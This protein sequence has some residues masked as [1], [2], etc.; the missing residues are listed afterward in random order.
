M[1]RVIVFVLSFLMYSG[2]TLGQKTIELSNP[3]FEDY[4]HLGQKN[5]SIN[6]WTDCGRINFPDETPPDIHKGRDTSSLINEIYFGVE[7]KATDGSTFLGMVVRDNGTYEAISQRLSS[8]IEGGKCYSFSIDL[9]HSLSYLSV[10]N[11]SNS[12]AK[13][14]TTPA[15]LQIYGGSTPCGKREKLAESISIKNTDWKTYEFTFTPKN[16]HRYITL[17]AYYNEKKS[18]PYNGN[19]LLDNASVITE[20]P[21]PNQLTEK[22]KITINKKLNKRTLKKGQIIKVNNLYFD[23]DSIVINPNSI[24]ALEE[25]ASFLQYYPEIIIEIGGHTNGRPT[26]EFCDSLSEA[27]AKNV[28]QFLYN[29]GIPRQQVEFKGYGKRKPIASNNYADGRRRN[30]R[31][32]IK[33]LSVE[34]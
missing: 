16:S 11:R 9:S 23:A 27:R 25:L 19:I 30:Q 31:V 29:K 4:P 12:N 1:D 18:S 8:Q 34:S 2:I 10:N 13:K 6:G 3:S 5:S 22:P 17:V 26:H 20:I 7:E 21:C 32:E 24:P 15:V 14:L 28:A 33:V